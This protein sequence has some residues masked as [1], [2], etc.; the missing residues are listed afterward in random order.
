MRKIVLQEFLTL[1]G[2]MQAPGGPDEDASGGFRFGGWTAPYFSAADAESG[3]FM[4]RHL[5]PADLLLGRRTYEIFADYWPK[6]ADGW[7]GVLDVMKYVVSTTMSEAQVAGSGWRNSVLLKSID[8]VEALVRSEG[9][10]LKVIGSSVLA[11]SLLAR[12]LV[13][14]LVLMTF[15]VVL[16][17]GKRLFAEGA[18]PAAFVLSDRVVTTNGAFLAHYKR[19]GEVR[20]GT[21][22]A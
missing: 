21:V 2:V 9:S 22:G 19:A 7:P 14:E 13:D 8:D 20:T 11:Q 10:D 6:H 3:E 5:A 12:D 4:A 18:V 1:D 15:P 16:G 17:S